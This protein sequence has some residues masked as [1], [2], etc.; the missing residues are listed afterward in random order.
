LPLSK[1]S[2][3]KFQESSKWYLALSYKASGKK[4]KAKSLLKQIAQKNNGYQ[5]MAADSLKLME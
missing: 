3:S 1:N 5:Q 4:E 2:K